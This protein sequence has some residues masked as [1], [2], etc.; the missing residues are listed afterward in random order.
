MPRPIVVTLVAAAALVATGIS[1]STR[2]WRRGW[3]ESSI[4][5]LSITL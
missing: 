4:T 1:S 5:A 3:K 2:R